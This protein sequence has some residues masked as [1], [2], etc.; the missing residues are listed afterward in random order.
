MTDDWLLGTGIAP[1]FYESDPVPDDGLIKTCIQVSSNSDVDLLSKA[2]ED[3][4]KFIQINF[5]SVYQ[6]YCPPGID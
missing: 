5:P 2:Y 1:A 3:E 6:I 4:G